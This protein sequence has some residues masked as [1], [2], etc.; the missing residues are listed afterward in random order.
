MQACEEMDVQ[1]LPTIILSDEE[2]ERKL[3]KLIKGNE[4]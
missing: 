3:A 2:K 1:E 4:F